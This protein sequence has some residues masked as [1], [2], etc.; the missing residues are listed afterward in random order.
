[1][2]ETLTQL[3][4]NYNG[5]IRLD[6]RLKREFDIGVSSVRVSLGDEEEFLKLST[7][8]SSHF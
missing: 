7:I 1:M 5:V 3:I 6:G 8:S 2:T 4:K